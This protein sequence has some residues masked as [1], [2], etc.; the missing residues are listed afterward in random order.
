VGRLLHEADDASGG[1]NV[2]VLSHHYWQ[3]RFSGNPNVVNDTLIVNGQP[4]TIV[5]VAPAGFDG[6]TIGERPAVFVPIRLAEQMEPGRKLIENRRAYWIYFFA[7]LKPGIDIDAATAAIN[8]P[9][10]SVIQQ[11]EAPL[12]KGMSAPALERFKAKAIEL[13]DGRRGQSSTPDDAFAPLLILLIVT[14]VVLLSACANIANL[15]LTKAVGRAAEMAVRLSIGAA[16]RQLIGQLLGESLVLAI[17]GG[18]FGLLVAQWTMA[19]VTSLLPPDTAQAMTF[20]LD[21]RVLLFMT[22]VTVGTGLLFGVFP[23]LHGTRPNL[24]TTLKGQAGQPGGS[25]SAKRFRMGLATA[26]VM[27]SMA[28]LAIS[29]LFLKSLVNVSRVDLGLQ[30]ANV[31]GFGIAP[32]LNGYTPERAKQIYE[33][34]EQALARLPGVTS[35]AGSMVPVLSGNNWGTN[36]SVEGVRAEPDADMHSFLNAVGPDFFKT[37]GI[38]LLAGR[39]FTTADTLGT[40]KVAIVNQA[41]AKKFNLGPNPVGKRMAQGTGKLDM[42]IVGLVKDA[43]YS[44]VKGKV[45]ELFYTPYRQTERM[46]SLG[47]YAA[48]TGP[49][50]A[51]LSAIAPMMARIDPTLPVGELRTLEEQA[52]SNVYEDRLVST[53]ASVFAGLATLLA[54][55]GLYGVLAY[56]VAQRTREFGL[57]MALGAD[58]GMIRRLVLRQVAVMT[59]M[60]AAAGLTIAMIAG[61]YARTLLF[62]MSGIDPVVLSASA[63]VLGV[64]AVLAGLIPAFR[65]SRV[66]PMFALRYE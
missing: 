43:K 45:P 27:L 26:Q 64:V 53:L 9:Y 3:T 1:A 17:F 14:F 22:A 58:G 48:T 65:A 49:T 6:T 35:V 46:G 63:G 28:L 41:F 30:T 33:Q 62:E 18:L 21:T 37:L 4:F 16:R 13:S 34:V 5:G 55:I 57:R 47:F 7:R 24:A 36:V 29:G 39:D 12:Q 54:A 10:R 42:E 44:E 25:R 56:T 66:D 8:Q 31:V 15:L 32:Q 60:G 11:V 61:W 50:D 51:V 23:A 2:V 40:P 59:V 20:A 38:P 52:R 19:T